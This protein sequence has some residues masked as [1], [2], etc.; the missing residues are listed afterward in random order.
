M[1]DTLFFIV[2]NMVSY[3]K[4]LVVN[5]EETDGII[6]F[7]ITVAKEDIGRVIG[8][9]GK[10]IKAIRNVMKIPALKENKRINITLTEN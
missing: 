7:N 8:K 10:I 3:P 4:K 2:S 6:N 1:K 9:E 5:E